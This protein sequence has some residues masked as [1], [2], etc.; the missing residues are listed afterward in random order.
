MTKNFEKTYIPRTEWLHMFTR[1]QDFKDDYNEYNN[2]MSV[3]IDQHK[4]HIDGIVD[5][6]ILEQLEDRLQQYEDVRT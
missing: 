6:S 4:A 2:K 1:M 5:Q 3:A